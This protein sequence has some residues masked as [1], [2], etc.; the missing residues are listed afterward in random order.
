MNMVHVLVVGKKI[1]RVPGR[2][3]GVPRDE[4][5]R[6]GS[7]SCDDGGGNS[8]FTV[9]LDTLGDGWRT[10]VRPGQRVRIEQV[11]QLLPMDK[12]LLRRYAHC[13]G[14]CSRKCPMYPFATG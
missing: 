9:L 13:V 5:L 1:P 11:H 6:I 14:S 7:L 2:Q 4:C 12:G 10:G 8:L 3:V